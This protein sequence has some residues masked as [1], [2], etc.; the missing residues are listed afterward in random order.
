MVVCCLILM[1][2]WGVNWRL[3]GSSNH[4]RLMGI[5]LVCLLIV[6][7]GKRL[8]MRILRRWS[9]VKGVGEVTG[10]VIKKK[11]FVTDKSTDGPILRS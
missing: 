5:A 8:G 7:P 10:E 4:L 1:L 11:A 3:L 9:K 6:L 2:V